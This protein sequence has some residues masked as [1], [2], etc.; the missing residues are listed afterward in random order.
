MI[1]SDYIVYKHTNKI[2]NKSYIGITCQTL[3]NRSRKNG[4]GYKE[5][6]RFYNAIKKYGWNNFNHEILYNN[7]TKEQAEQKEIELIAKHKTN[8]KNYGYNIQNGGN[9]IGR[10]AEET[11]NKISKALKGITLTEEHKRKIGDAQTG[12]KNHNFGK[13]TSNEIKNKIRIGNLLHPSSGCFKSH[14]VNQYDLEGNFIK[15][16]NN[17]G[18]IKRELGINHSMISECCN[19]KQKTSGGYKWEY[20]Q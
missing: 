19:G 13:K 7:L 3:K 16:W 15:T 9:T 6:I 12:E 10:M 18:E 17:M 5:C 2:N 20:C 11:K 8:N 1:L 4:I 14:K